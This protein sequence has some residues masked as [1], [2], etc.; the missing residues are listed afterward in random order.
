[1]SLRRACLFACL[2]DCLPSRAFSV[3]WSRKRGPACIAVLAFF[4]FSF[5][6]LFFVAT[7]ISVKS[8][9]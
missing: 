8:G 7:L 6:F 2:F 5:S 4:S 1:M 3:D 9:I